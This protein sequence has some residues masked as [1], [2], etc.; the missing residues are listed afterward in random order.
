MVGGIVIVY[1]VAGGTKA[2]SV[3]QKQQMIVILTG[4]FLAAVFLV[5]QLPEGIGFSDS[6]NVAGKLGKLE[7]IDF[8]FDLSSRYNIWS[9]L[10]AGLFLFMSYFG[11]DQSQVQRYLSGKSLANGLRILPVCKA[12]DSL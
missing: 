2:V 10:L 5:Y 11:T 4:M 1:T 3:T 9:G 8:E 7:L 12:S 6:L